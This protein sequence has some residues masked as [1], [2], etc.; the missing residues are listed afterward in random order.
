MQPTHWKIAGAAVA[1]LTLM[2]LA[3]AAEPIK[4]N[5]K[6]GLWE[7]ASQGQFTGAP[8]IPD[9]QLARLTPEQRARF[10]AA[11]QASMANAA[12]PRLSKNCVTPE[13]IARG[14]D[15]DQQHNDNSCQRKVLANSAS[16]VEFSEECSSD[17]GKSVINEHFQLS[18]SELMTGS[19]HVVRTSGDKSMTVDSTIH[20]KWLGASC[21]DIKDFEI[22]KQ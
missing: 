15:L 11:M 8:P 19:V 21:G 22:E 16:E 13:K 5:L 3:E 18:G 10:E 1:G 12:K 4:L 17:S 7:I 9:D 6:P 14:L 20:G 2:L